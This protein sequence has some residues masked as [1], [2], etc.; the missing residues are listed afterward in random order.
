MEWEPDG[1]TGAGP[2]HRPPRGFVAN[3]AA[4]FDDGYITISFVNRSVQPRHQDIY[5]VQIAALA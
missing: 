1:T 2:F 3:P 4:D 5:K